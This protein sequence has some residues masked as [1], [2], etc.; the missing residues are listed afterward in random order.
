MSDPSAVPE[1]SADQLPVPVDGSDPAPVAEPSAVPEPSGVP[2]VPV[3]AATPVVPEGTGTP[4]ESDA[5]ELAPGPATG[6]DDPSPA[7]ACPAATV[8]GA[9]QL[10]AGSARTTPGDPAEGPSGDDDASGPEGCHPEAADASPTRPAASQPA[11][12]RAA[13]DD[14]CTAAS[15]TLAAACL[16]GAG[17]STDVSD[18]IAACQS[19]SRTATAAAGSTPSGTSSS[20]AARAAPQQVSDVEQGKGDRIGSRPAGP[21]TQGSHGHGQSDELNPD[22]VRSNGAPLHHDPQ[23]EPLAPMPPPPPVPAS[24]AS[25]AG[26]HAGGP[27]TGEKQAMPK[28]TLARSD[29]IQPADFGVRITDGDTGFVIGGAS[30][31]GFRP[32]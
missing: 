15:P 24:S 17:M 4:P 13:D 19:A 16:P 31:S 27:S 5:E 22:P 21:W 6:T 26:A 7:A 2:P 14:V 1:P 3:D 8:D 9:A 29:V 25:A 20:T 23:P 11:G 10:G 28:A 18:L 32:D 12:T 30:D